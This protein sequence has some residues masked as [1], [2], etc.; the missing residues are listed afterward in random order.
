MSTDTSLDASISH[1][2]ISYL[3]ASYQ[4]RFAYYNLL[5]QIKHPA[6]DEG[7]LEETRETLE[8][9]AEWS[10]DLLSGATL[11]SSTWTFPETF[12]AKKAMELLRELASEM[13]AFAVEVQKIFKTAKIGK[14]PDHFKFLI[15][16]FGRF[17]YS[18][19]NYIKAFIEF[20]KAFEYPE[21]VSQYEALLKNSDGDLNLTNE[22]LQHLEEK[23]EA[24]PVFYAALNQSTA[25]LPAIFKTHVHDIRQLIAQFN[26]G[27]SYEAANFNEK[28]AYSWSMKGFDPV[29]AGYWAAYE[30][31]PESAKAWCDVGLTEPATSVEWDRYNFQPEAAIPWLKAGFPAAIAERWERFGHG[32][33]KAMK[34]MKQG[35]KD[36]QE[37]ESKGEA[38][39]VPDTNPKA[40]DN[41]D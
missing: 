36:P 27:F 29:T 9:V 41:K 21:M 3:N 38:E 8:R 18:R 10:Q 24:E 12:E 26:G 14:T 16:A 20:G 13:D 39:P 35:I 19:N 22:F 6:A 15:A 25:S 4:G 32:P 40:N 37:L 1:A 30:I 23:K 11:F 5:K 7:A 33:E 34:L 28:D 31:S 17:A 2:I